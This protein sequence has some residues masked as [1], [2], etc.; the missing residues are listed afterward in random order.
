M[1]YNVRMQIT[2]RI[3]QLL[4][5]FRT[6]DQQDFVN[7]YLAPMLIEA[8]GNLDSARDTNDMLRYQGQVR[9]LKQV[10]SD[11][12]ASDGVLLKMKQHARKST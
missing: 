3:A 1:S 8:R 9:L 11:I 2:Q 5:R 6:G 10:L 12:E 4:T 7:E